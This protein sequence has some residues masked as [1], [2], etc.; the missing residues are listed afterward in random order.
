MEP[1][2][3]EGLSIGCGVSFQSNEMGRLFHV[4]GITVIR[5]ARTVE[6]AGAG[7]NLLITLDPGGNSAGDKGAAS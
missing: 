1:T 4:N 3:S 6:R 2:G 7:D 5:E